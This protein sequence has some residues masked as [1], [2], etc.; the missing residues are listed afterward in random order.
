MALKKILITGY[1]VFDGRDINGSETLATHLNGLQIGDF[2][3]ESKVLPVTWQAVDD[4][5]ESLDDGDYEMI[6]SFG[7][8]SPELTEPVFETTARNTTGKAD[9]LGAAAPHDSVMPDGPDTIASGLS[10]TN[11]DMPTSDDAGAYLCNYLLY[12]LLYLTNMPATFIHLPI[13]GDTHRAIYTRQ[14]EKAVVDL[15]AHNVELLLQV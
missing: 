6:F 14:N 2:I 11:D 7:E 15:I 12:K 9:V 8:G 13:Q 5:V 10:P 1:S 4:F 3:L